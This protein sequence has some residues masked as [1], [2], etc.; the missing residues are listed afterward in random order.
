MVA[1]RELK[2]E[3]NDFLDNHLRR[4][5]NIWIKGHAGS[6]KSVLLVYSVKHYLS[7]Y[8]AHDV[9]VV[10]YT[11][12]LIDLI[13]TG[14]KAIGASN[15]PIMTYFAFKNDNRH[16]YKAIF[17]DEIQDI[18]NYVLKIMNQRA[19]RIVAA[20]DQMQSIY[21]DG[22]SPEEIKSTLS[23]TEYPLNDIH[24]LTKSIVTIVAKFLGNI[25]NILRGKIINA[26]KDTDINVG[27][28]SNIDSET[29]YVWK[30][31]KA[32]AEAG[33][34]TAVLLPTHEDIQNFFDHVCKFEEVNEWRRSYIQKPGKKMPDYDDLNRHFERHDIPFEYVGNSFGSLDNAGNGNKVI[35]MTYHSAKGLDFENVFM[36]WLTDRLKIVGKTDELKETV[37]M[38]ALTR[39]RN[40]LNLTY[41]GRA[42]HPYLDKFIDEDCVTTFDIDGELLVSGEANSKHSTDW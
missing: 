18:P 3:Q 9:A 11:H 41:H 1:Q 30:R 6:G 12:A 4:S 34:P 32:Y 29:E 35:V 8:N 17:V 16:H 22:A 21:A 38:V 31:S 10:V 5:G 24:R 23:A 20:G 27:R 19:D 40:N 42:Y 33:Y 28:G 7:K 15:V 36:P 2:D 25:G 14:L 13:G 26:S 39:S 37:F